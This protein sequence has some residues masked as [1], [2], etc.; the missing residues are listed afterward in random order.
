[1]QDNQ[2]IQGLFDRDCTHL[3]VSDASGQLDDEEKPAPQILSV[4]KRSSSIGQSRIRGEQLIGA[5]GS[6]EYALMHLRKGLPMKTVRPGHSLAE[7]VGEG[8]STAG[9]DAFG[10]AAPV[11]A[12][13]S[14]IRTDLDFFSHTEAR[15]LELDGYLMSVYELEEEGFDQLGDGSAAAAEPAQWD[16]GSM[17]EQIGGGDE[18]YVS[19]LEAGSRSFFRLLALRPAVGI[20]WGAAIAIVLALIAAAISWPALCLLRGQ[21]WWAFVAGTTLA[22]SIFAVISL[23]VFSNLS[24]AKGKLYPS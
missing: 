14:N 19:R 16:F 18:S 3:I 15:S 22:V 8:G 10:V 17:L 5:A 21:P 20:G 9:T 13:L 24:L 1:M 4:L 6:Y 2:G 7:A 12:A 23:F 11:Q